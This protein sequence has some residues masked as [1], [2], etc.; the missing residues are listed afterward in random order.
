MNNLIWFQND[1]RVADQQS[2]SIAC[3]GNS[4]IAVYFFDPRRYQAGDFGFK[5]TE[6]YRAQFLLESVNEL[7]A[8][9]KALNI[10][11]LVYHAKP[12]NV[13]PQLVEQYAIDA[14]YLQKEWT[15][16]ES[17]VLETVVKRIPDAIKVETCYD[18]FLF[19]PDDIPYSNFKDIPKV[20]TQ[21]RK[22]CEKES[23]VRA[24]IAQPTPMPDSNLIENTT[25][26]PDLETL[27]LE[28]FEP[29]ARSAF[30]FK[31]GEDQALRRIKNYFWDT[32]HLARYKKTRNGLI[33]ESYSAK[34]SAWL[35]NGSISARTIYAEVVRFEK[36][37]EKNESTY[38]LIFELIW[39][40]F[41]KY[42]SLKHGDQ[43]F[44]IEGI[45]NK[46]YDWDTSSVAQE[47]MD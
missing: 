22:K 19:H 31:G 9:L 20:Y 15:S 42:V 12:E 27:G 1:L 39:R 37:V 17:R 45:L 5:R 41:F 18:Q 2:L 21:F 47:K 10:S 33:G 28:R 4:V 38:W 24:P 6:K 36:E 35:A 25:Q 23:S 13:F 40:D 7:K 32:K 43:L 11:L 34:L 46:Q 30:P 16:E 44:K 26:L 29:D 8:N 3:G 14:I